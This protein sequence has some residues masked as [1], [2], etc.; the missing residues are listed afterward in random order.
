MA[1]SPQAVMGRAV[2][3]GCGLRGV[4]WG[5]WVSASEVVASPRLTMGLAG[6][7]HLGSWVVAELGWR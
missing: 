7:G 4:G 3:A 5:G 2:G 1:A 6:V